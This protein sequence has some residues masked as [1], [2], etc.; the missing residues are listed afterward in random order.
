M[1]CPNCNQDLPA[2]ASIC[3]FCGAPVAAAPTPHAGPVLY[4]PAASPALPGSSGLSTAGLVLGI[5]GVVALVLVYGI[6]LALL[7][8]LIGA[9]G[10]QPAVEDIQRLA[11]G[12]EFVAVA[13]LYVLAILF[14]LIG[15]ILSIV[16]VA[17]ESKRPTRYGKALGIVG[18]SLGSIPLLC[19][20]TS[21]LLGILT[22]TA[23]S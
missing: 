2:G 13:A 12:P 17:Q 19:C 1:R 20:V 15:L 10:E 22:F 16:G 7:M 14:A 9:A 8:P 3:Q 18:I 5:L 23:G 11:T 6:Y 21:L 4:E